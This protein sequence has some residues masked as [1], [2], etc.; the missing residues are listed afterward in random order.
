MGINTVTLGQSEHK[1]FKPSEA[2][3]TTERNVQQPQRDW[4][5]QGCIPNNYIALGI[6]ID[7][8]GQW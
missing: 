3:Q 5:E 4:I 8:P 1:Q 2:A 6:N 7:T